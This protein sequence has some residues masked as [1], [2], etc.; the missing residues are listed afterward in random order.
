M[1]YET[2][3]KHFGDRMSPPGRG[4]ISA[5]IFLDDTMKTSNKVNVLIEN[6]LVAKEGLNYGQMHTDERATYNIMYKTF[7]TKDE[8]DK[9][10]LIELLALRASRLAQTG[11]DGHNIV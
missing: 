10:D 6:D 4:F 11:A 2:A 3:I 5:D 8:D 9:S 1:F 7:L